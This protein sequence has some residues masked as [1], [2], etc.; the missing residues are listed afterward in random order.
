MSRSVVILRG[1]QANPW[2]LKPWGS[3]GTD[4]DVSVVVP[5]NN[6]Y[7]VAGLGLPRRRARTLSSLLPGPLVRVPGER[8]LGFEALVREAD[9]VHA[10]ELGYWFSWQAARA[11]ER[12]G[13]RLVVTVWE[14][15]PFLDAYRNARTR[16]YRRDVLSATDLFLATT[17]RARAALLIEGAPEERVRVCAPGVD[18]SLFAAA[19]TLR[20]RDDGAQVVLTVARLVWEKG[21]QDLLR[22]L[23][24]LDRPDVVAVIAGEGPDRAR[25]ERHAQELGVRAEFAGAIPYSEMPAL[26]AQAS[27]FVLGSLPIWS[28]EEQFG[29]VLAEALA[30]H[31]PIVAAASGAIPEVLD[32]AGTLFAPGDW[33][34]LAQALRS[35]LDGEP[36]VDPGPLAD[37]YTTEAA[38]ARLREAY[39]A[40]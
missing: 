5:R 29:M 8:Y 13:Y 32:G 22:A 19:R 17:E 25:L 7:D 2:D 39:G 26:Y 40:L 30:A 21:I 10:A 38:A 20:P 24:A 1:R 15:L 35:A 18:L 9:I 4:Y 37:R 34:G 28:W 33:L 14:T 3:L 6:R 36:R 31:L 27:C 16:R 23:A 12:H 11:R